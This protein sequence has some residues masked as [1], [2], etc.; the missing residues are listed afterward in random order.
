[1]TLKVSCYM[2]IAC[3]SLACQ[4]HEVVSKFDICK[5]YSVAD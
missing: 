3:S 5:L 1:M 2:V 4:L